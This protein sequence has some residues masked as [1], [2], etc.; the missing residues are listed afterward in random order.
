MRK[1][2]EKEIKIHPN[3]MGCRIYAKNRRFVNLFNFS[4]PL[5]VTHLL[6]EERT[7]NKTELIP[8]EAKIIEISV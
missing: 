6:P 5:L 3:V 4:I 8:N 1:I 2:I 7:P